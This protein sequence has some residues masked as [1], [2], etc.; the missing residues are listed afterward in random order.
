MNERLDL[1]DL[2]AIRDRTDLN[3]DEKQKLIEETTNGYGLRIPTEPGNAGVGF[4]KGG[5]KFFGGIDPAGQ[6][7]LTTIYRDSEGVVRV[8]NMSFED[9]A[10][11]EEFRTATN[12]MFN[13]L[14]KQEGTPEY[15]GSLPDAHLAM[16]QIFG[17]H[18]K[19]THEDEH[20]HRAS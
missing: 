20:K 10:V 18:R 13:A 4:V 12:E 16:F 17:L 5:V 9:A 3:D 6:P 19:D 15:Q 8:I 14:G 2:E 1:T 11:I 7:T